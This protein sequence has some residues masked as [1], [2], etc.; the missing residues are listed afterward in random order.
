MVKPRFTNFSRKLAWE[1]Q[2]CRC[3]MVVFTLTHSLKYELNPK[4][5]T[6]KFLCNEF[7]PVPLPPHLVHVFY[8]M[9]FSA[10]ISA[11][12]LQSRTRSKKQT[13]KYGFSTERHQLLRQESRS[14][15]GFCRHPPSQ[16]EGSRHRCPFC[17]SPRPCVCVK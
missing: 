12:L 13:Q 1:R 3:L 2:S 15:H 16:I 10:A 6:A 17:R 5:S 8:K 14:C 4:P 11:L 7:C 9:L